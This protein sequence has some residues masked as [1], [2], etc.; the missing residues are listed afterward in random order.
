MP[1]EAAIRNVLD[2]ALDDMGVIYADSGDVHT[3]AAALVLAHATYALTDEIRTLNAKMIEVETTLDAIQ[4][5]QEAQ[6][7]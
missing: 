1:T 7:P 3:P 5:A 4:V 2:S 6:V